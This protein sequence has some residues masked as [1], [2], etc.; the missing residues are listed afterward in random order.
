MQGPAS[1]ESAI[2]ASLGNRKTKQTRI[3]DPKTPVLRF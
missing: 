1:A 2:V 3:S